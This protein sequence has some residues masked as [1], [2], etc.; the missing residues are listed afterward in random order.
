MYWR[1]VNIPFLAFYRRCRKTAEMESWSQERFLMQWPTGA[2]THSITFK[3]VGFE[4]QILKI[5]NKYGLCIWHASVC[6]C[7][8]F[9]CVCVW[10]VWVCGLCVCGLCVWFVWFCVCVICEYMFWFLCVYIWCVC[11]FSVHIVLYVQ[12]VCV[13][14]CVCAY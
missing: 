7:V 9:V 10:F 6:V 14:V 3:P 8:W 2:Y 1:F 5:E 12:L 4:F 13:F 11:V